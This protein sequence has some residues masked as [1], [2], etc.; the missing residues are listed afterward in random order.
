MYMCA[1]KERRIY[2]DIFVYIH[3]MCVW[4]HWKGALGF[5]LHTLRPQAATGAM[6]DAACAPEFGATLGP[7]GTSLHGF[8]HRS[9]LGS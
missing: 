5:K 4:Q 8:H 3:N 6:M 9:N 7:W 2:A 1:W